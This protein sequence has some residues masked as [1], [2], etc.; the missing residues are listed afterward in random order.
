MRLLFTLLLLHVN[1]T[2]FAQVEKHSLGVN[3][4]MP[5]LLQI[6]YEYQVNDNF[7]LALGHSPLNIYRN[8]RG[9][10]Y[11]KSFSFSLTAAHTLIRTGKSKMNKLLISGGAFYGYDGDASFPGSKFLRESNDFTPFL[12]TYSVKNDIAF[13]SGLSFEFALFDLFSMEFFL[14]WY[15][16]TNPNY[17]Y[18]HNWILSAPFPLPAFTIKR[19]FA[20]RE[21]KNQTEDNF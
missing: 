9:R 6:Q 11:P 18:A 16:F 15:L 21:V 17:R 1:L 5:N 13:Y 4:L 2:F 20:K 7:R 14:N 12:S 3:M 19:S 8:Q 10:I